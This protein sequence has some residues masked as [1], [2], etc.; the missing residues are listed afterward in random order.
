MKGSRLVDIYKKGFALKVFFQ[1]GRGAGSKNREKAAPSNSS[2]ALRQSHCCRN[3][4]CGL[5]GHWD[6]Q[7]HVS[8]H[9]TRNVN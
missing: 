8:F 1:Q 7:C 2:G 5:L 3:L 6:D 4:C 9:A